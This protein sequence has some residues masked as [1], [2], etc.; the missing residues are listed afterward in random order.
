MLEKFN[1]WGMIRLNRIFQ[2]FPAFWKL[3]NAQFSK[4]SCY[5]RYSIINEWPQ[6]AKWWWWA[7][8]HV[9]IHSIERS[10]QICNI[11][12]GCNTKSVHNMTSGSRSTEARMLFFAQL[13]SPV[14]LPKCHRD[15][16]WWS[17]LTL[18]RRGNFEH[19]YQFFTHIANFQS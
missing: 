18:I 1:G 12:R 15:L 4:N 17:V 6:Y 11:W 8:P 19:R 3:M 2:L 5:S 14:D 13:A 16:Q 9:Q 10:G 7:R